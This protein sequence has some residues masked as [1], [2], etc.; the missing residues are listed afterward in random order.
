M[1]LITPLSFS[2][3]FTKTTKA[4]R[5]VLVW[6]TAIGFLAFILGIIIAIIREV[7]QKTDAKRIIADN[8][9]AKPRLLTNRMF[10]PAGTKRIGLSIINPIHSNR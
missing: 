1:L 8:V 3:P 5:E 9:K 6:G 7:K 4:E 2:K 10:V